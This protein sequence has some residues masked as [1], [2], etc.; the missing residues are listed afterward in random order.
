MKSIKIYMH[1]NASPLAPSDWLSIFAAP[2][3]KLELFW[4]VA[5]EIHVACQQFTEV[6]LTKTKDQLANCKHPVP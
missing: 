3:D 4:V 1:I 6:P 2:R 5:M